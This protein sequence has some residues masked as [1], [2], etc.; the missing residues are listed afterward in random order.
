MYTSNLYVGP[1]DPIHRGRAMLEKH[2]FLRR[3]NIY[4]ISEQV[5]LLNTG[6]GMWKNHDVSV[7]SETC[8]RTRILYQNC[9]L[10]LAVIICGKVRYEKI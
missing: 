5:N 9:E 6:L 10:S 1:T 8:D 2:V 4:L 7:K 3:K